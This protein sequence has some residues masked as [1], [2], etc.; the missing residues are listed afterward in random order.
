MTACNLA[1]YDALHASPSDGVP[2]CLVP[3]YGA[4]PCEH[5]LEVQRVLSVEP[6]VV[7]VVGY[8][9]FPHRHLRGSKLLC[10]LSV[11]MRIVRSVLRCVVRDAVYESDGGDRVV[12]HVQPA[13]VECDGSVFVPVQRSC[14]RVMTCSV[15][16]DDVLAAKP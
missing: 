14:D 2:V 7:L 6:C 15:P 12:V 11:C 16:S 13:E 3:I 5:L 4:L 8:A 1:V 9:L 10:L